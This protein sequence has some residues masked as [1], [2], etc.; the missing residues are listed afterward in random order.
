M[1]TDQ[2]VRFDNREGISPVKKTG[3]LSQR[4]PNAVRRSPRFC[5]SLNIKA[6]LL[7]QK[8][9]LGSDSGGERRPR[10]KKVKM[11]ANT[12]RL[13]QIN[14][15]TGE[16]VQT[17]DV[18]TQFYEITAQMRFGQRDLIFAEH[19]IVT[20]RP[21]LPQDAEPCNILSRPVH[22]FHPG[23]ELSEAIQRGTKP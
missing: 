19:R 2:S 7:S 13:F 1:P 14:A 4:E 18:I 12:S 5:F 11:S 15:A 20:V 10:R 8:Q 23:R 17:G 22:G 6:E 3:Q 9:V 21:R 16:R